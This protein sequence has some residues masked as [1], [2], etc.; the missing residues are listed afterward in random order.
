MTCSNISHFSLNVTLSIGLISYKIRS[1]I[2][3][4]DKIS[5]AG[6]NNSNKAGKI[7]APVLLQRKSLKL[8]IILTFPLILVYPATPVSGNAGISPHFP[9]SRPEFSLR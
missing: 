2:W 5:T 6:H 9:S 1:T 3:E 7:Q 4:A 8:F